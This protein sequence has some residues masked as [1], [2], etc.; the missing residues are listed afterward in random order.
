MSHFRSLQVA[1]LL[2]LLALAGCSGASGVTMTGTATLDGKALDNATLDFMPL[3]KGQGGEKVMTDAQGN[4][5]IVPDKRKKGLIPGTKYGVRVSRW[6]D[7]KTKAP[8]PPEEVEQL[9]M[10][11]FLENTVPF[12]YWDPESN[13][14]IV[15]EV[16]PGKNE[17]VQITL[18]SD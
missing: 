8:P 4:F 13:P 18:K 14:P 16:K 10:G 11:G 15:I 3:D 9:Q 12:R 17:G 2:P 5:K 1:L 7:K 6:V